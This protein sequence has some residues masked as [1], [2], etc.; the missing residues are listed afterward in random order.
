ME[1]TLAVI[2]P[3]GLLGG[4]STPKDTTKI[5]TTIV[6][7]C[8]IKGTT[9]KIILDRELYNHKDYLWGAVCSKIAPCPY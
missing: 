7:S 6:A 3:S 9:E 4:Y 2:V 8:L 5:T 1:I